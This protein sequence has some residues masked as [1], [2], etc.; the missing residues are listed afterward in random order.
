GGVVPS[1]VPGG[2]RPELLQM[3]ADGDAVQQ[4]RRRV[5]RDPAEPGAEP[6]GIE[7]ALVIWAVVDGRPADAR[8]PRDSGGGKT[9]GVQPGLR[10][11]C[12]APADAAR[13]ARVRP[14]D[15]H[16]HAGQLAGPRVCR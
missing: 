13:A 7:S 11:R 6:A 15:R 8:V 4:L 1:Y 16:V 14:E 10:V 12:S 5:L 9:R 3:V 2:E